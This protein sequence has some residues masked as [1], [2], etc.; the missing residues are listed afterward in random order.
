VTTCRERRERAKEERKENEGA[1]VES[2][3]RESVF[4]ATFCTLAE[5]LSLATD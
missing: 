4:L 5:L 3:R 1:P 2:G